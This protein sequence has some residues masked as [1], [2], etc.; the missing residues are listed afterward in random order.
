[1]QQDRRDD[2]DTT[3]LNLRRQAGSV[4]GGLRLST[5][6]RSGDPNGKD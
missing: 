6:S 5:F 4:A 2:A 1:M 3:E